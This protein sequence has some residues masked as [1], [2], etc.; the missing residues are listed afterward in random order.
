MNQTFSLDSPASATD[1]EALEAQHRAEQP[2]F[3]P[4]AEALERQRLADLTL[5]P[6]TLQV[7][8]SLIDVEQI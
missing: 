2:R 4:L 1:W 5:D 3:M 8:A 7:D 6:S